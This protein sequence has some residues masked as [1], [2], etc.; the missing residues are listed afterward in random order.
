MDIKEKIIIKDKQV[1]TELLQKKDVNSIS[2]NV[3]TATLTWTSDIDFDLSVLAFCE[4]TGKHAFIYYSN[5]SYYSGKKTDIKLDKD[6]GIGDVGGNNSETIKLRLTDEFTH[7]VF[8]VWDYKMLM[9]DKTARFTKSDLAITYTLNDKEQLMTKLNSFE[10]GNV[11]CL[12]SVYKENEEYL[13][14]N[15]SEIK[16]IKFRVGSSISENV[17]SLGLENILKNTNINL[18]QDILNNKEENKYFYREKL[19]EFIKSKYNIPIDFLNILTDVIVKEYFNE[20]VV[21]PTKEETKEKQRSFL[22]KLFNW[23]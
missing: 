21:L 10:E 12:S 16:N 17:I 3:I 11:I 22:D 6:A 7:Y 20:G 9:Q 2:D 4:N 19:Y 5:K 15:I 13:I 8:M 1:I 18:V 14:K 23:Q